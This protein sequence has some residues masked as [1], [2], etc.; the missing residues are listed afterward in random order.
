M[1]AL[2]KAPFSIRSKPN[3]F[4]RV[5]ARLQTLL[6]SL[7][8][9]LA[10]RGQAAVNPTLSTGY[11]QIILATGGPDRPRAAPPAAAGPGCARL[12]GSAEGV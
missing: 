9:R 2:A 4:Q 12:D 6:T 11:P 3:P 8:R 5:A 10:H 7:L 1:T